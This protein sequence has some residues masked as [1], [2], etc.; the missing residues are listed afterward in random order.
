MLKDLRQVVRDWR[1]AVFLLG[2]PIIFTLM[3]G[4]A[5]GGFGGT[6]QGDPRLPV[7]FADQDQGQM[8]AQLETLL[9]GSAV[10][11]LEYDGA[12][13]TELEEL[14][15]DGDLAAAIIVPAGYSDDLLAGGAPQL[16]LVTDPGS[17]AGIATQAEV[18]SAANR[19]H[20]AVFAAGLS[21]RIYDERVGFSDAGARQAYFDDRLAEGVTAWEDPPIS[22]SSQLAIV[23]QDED[24]SENAFAQSS[25]G[26]MAQFSV[27]GL[28]GAVTIL[29]MER[30]SGAMKRLLT[31]NLSRGQILLGHY[32]AMVVM[33]FAQL[34]IL[35][36]FG[37]LLL[38]LN[39]LS[40]PAATLLV[41]VAAS[42]FVAALGLL[43]GA[44]AKSEEQVT[45][46]ALIPMFIL[47]GL[48]GAWVPLEVMPAG[49]QAFAR[50]TPLAWVMTGF[51]DIVIRGQGLDAVWLPA[52]VLLAYAV[53]FFVLGVWRFRIE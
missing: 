45:V 1:A 22:V 16:V 29:V 17:N 4:F 37:Q 48:G 19:L 31:T 47:A 38:K 34:A 11:R 23:R 8:S 18:Q 7:G 3:F 21:G 5:F 2:M 6:G 24:D 27:A 53:V 41:I 9:A 13:Q 20:S 28:M 42:I 10:I 12:S 14:V 50:L 44:L 32:L 40:Q 36:M 30:K 15:A 51:Q 25:P 52:L 49:F 26:M 35:V 33:I 39:Y 43:I 46:L